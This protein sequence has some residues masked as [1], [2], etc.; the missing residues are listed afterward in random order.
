MELT[1]SELADGLYK[2]LEAVLNKY[3]WTTLCA[4]VLGVLE[5]LKTTTMLDHIDL[6]EDPDDDEDEDDED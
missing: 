1:Q 6:V 4:T 2:E 5:M 3:E